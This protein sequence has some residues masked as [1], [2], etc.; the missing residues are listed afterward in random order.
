MVGP[1]VSS[2]HRLARVLCASS[3]ARAAS[4]RVGVES[5]ASDEA[6]YTLPVE[7]AC[8]IHGEFNASTVLVTRSRVARLTAH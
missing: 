6:N 2:K 3:V 1:L 8:H 4:Q 7:P 5:A